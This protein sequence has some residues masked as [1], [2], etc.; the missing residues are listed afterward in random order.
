MVGRDAFLSA[1]RQARPARS[2]VFPLAI[3]ALGVVAGFADALALQ[4]ITAAHCLTA[5]FLIRA[6]AA[7]T[8]IGSRI[9]ICTTSGYLV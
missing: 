7:A 9:V 6:N 5:Y 1:L 2:D 4:H 8:A 3:V